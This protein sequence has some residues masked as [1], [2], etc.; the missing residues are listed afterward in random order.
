MRENRFG[1]S[2]MAGKR[3]AE[4]DF[5]GKSQLR[6]VEKILTFSCLCDV[7]N[8]YS[9]CGFNGENSVGSDWINGDQNAIHNESNARAH[10]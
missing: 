3:V 9:H 1:A 4:K 10:R 5:A 2:L 8:T 6:R 7:S